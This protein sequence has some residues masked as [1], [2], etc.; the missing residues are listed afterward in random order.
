MDTT[1]SWQ[2]YIF[3]YGIPIGYPNNTN[4]YHQDYAGDSGEWRWPLDP[5][6]TDMTVTPG[7]LMTSALAMFGKDSFFYVASNST[8]SNSTTLSY[9]T[10]TQ[11]ICQAGDIPFIR[12]SIFNTLMYDQIF[13]ACNDINNAAYYGGGE[14]SDLDPM[15]Y[16]WISTFNSGA[17]TYVDG[18]TFS[19]EALEIA[20]FFANQHWLIETATATKSMSAAAPRNIYT[21]PG[22]AIV[23]P[24]LKLYA[25]I[26]ISIL[27]GL[28]LLGLA[29]LVWYIY[30]VPT[31]TEKLDSCAIA[32]LTHDV[33]ARLFET[34]RK[35]DEKALRELKDCDG[36]VGLA[37]DDHDQGSMSEQKQHDDDAGSSSDEH[38][39]DAEL[40]AVDVASTGSREQAVASNGQA[41]QHEEGIRL[42]R[43]GPGVVA[44]R[45][46]SFAEWKPGSRKR[47]MAK[48]SLLEKGET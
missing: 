31:W 48:Q 44:R 41:L 38:N 1:N 17:D 42:V 33:D 45:H 10:A 37:E 21:S 26:T 39:F 20:M 18:K 2:D 46:G 29:L 47:K 35:P 40:G 16:Q 34:I 30:S 24:D 36:I 22:T 28:Q 43:G 3:Q 12:L 19:K 14:A 8:R 25:R 23:K 7:P 11:Q 5:F 32:Q 13:S 6:D 15:L 27:I 4:V 9:P